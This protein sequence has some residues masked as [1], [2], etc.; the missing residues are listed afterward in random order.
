MDSPLDFELGL[1]FTTVLQDRKGFENNDEKKRS[2]KMVF[3]GKI[4]GWN[5]VSGNITHRENQ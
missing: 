1:L 3:S 4:C 2:S 5:E